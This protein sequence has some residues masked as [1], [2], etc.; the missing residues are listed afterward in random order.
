MH[1]I[2]RD[3]VGFIQNGDPAILRVVNIATGKT[4]REFP[5]PAGNPKSVHGQFRHA[6]ITETGTILIAYMDNRKVA[7]Y[8]ADGRE[9]WSVAFPGGPW[10]AERLKNGNTLISSTRL[11][12]EVDAQ[13]ETVWEF[14]SADAPEYRITGFQIASRLPAR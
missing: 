5:L 4:E 1:P 3:R 12:R 7:E 8:D 6:R 11:V 13:S 9:V 10:A 2:G 14:Q